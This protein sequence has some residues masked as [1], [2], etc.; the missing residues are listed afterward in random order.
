MTDPRAPRDETLAEEPSTVD[1]SH[2]RGSTLLLV[3]RMLSIGINLVSQALITA[4]CRKRDFG[5]FA[6]ACSI[7]SVGQ[8]FM[9]LGLHRGATPF[10]AP[11]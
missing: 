4:T 8:V 3:G 11:V 7:A 9:T 10:F 2:V 6:L 1:T 5:A